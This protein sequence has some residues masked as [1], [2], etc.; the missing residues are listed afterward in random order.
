MSDPIRWEVYD[1]Y[2]NRVYLT[3]ERWEHI[4]SLDNH[5]EFIQF[6]EEL[7]ET[8][9][10]GTRKQDSENP[11][12][13]RYTKSFNRLNKDNTHIVTIVLFRYHSEDGEV[14]PNNYIVTA[15]QVE[16]Y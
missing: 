11:Q 8:V 14:S 10:Q 16:Q 13:Y 4:I 9:K 1:R 12:K 15:Y 3:Q 7:K 5:P 6:E 2:G